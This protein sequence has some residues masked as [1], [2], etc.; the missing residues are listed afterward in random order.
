MHGNFEFEALNFNF[1]NTEISENN[2]FLL[3]ALIYQ[4]LTDVITELVQFG[5]NVDSEDEISQTPI[6]YGIAFGK[7]RNAKE[8]KTWI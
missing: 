7:D 2:S 8:S 5:M 3:L 1:K 6:I 4:G